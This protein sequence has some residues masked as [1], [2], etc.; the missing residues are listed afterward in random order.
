MYADTELFMNIV[1]SVGNISNVHRDEL[2]VMELGGKVLG[3]L[4][5]LLKAH[6]DVLYQ[7]CQYKQ[8]YIYK[9]PLLASWFKRF[10]RIRGIGNSNIIIINSKGTVFSIS[11]FSQ[12]RSSI[13]SLSASNTNGTGTIFMPINISGNNTNIFY[14]LYLEIILIE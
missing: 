8:F 10:L 4:I 2:K 5:P 12:Y 14:Y 13:N 7:Y 1:V 3:R 6:L 11:I 9:H